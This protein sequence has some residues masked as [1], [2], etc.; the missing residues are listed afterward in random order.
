MNAVFK[1]ITPQPTDIGLLAWLNQAEPGD[2]I[3]Y[4]RGFLTVDRARET[5]KLLEDDRQVLCRI[6]NLALRLSNLGL[7]HLVQ[8]RI[9]PDCFS[10]VAVARKRD[11]EL[12]HFLDDGGQS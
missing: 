3:E 6:A 12:S 2:A 4:H 8:R 11:C 1:V 10:Y 7:I 5:S 9:K